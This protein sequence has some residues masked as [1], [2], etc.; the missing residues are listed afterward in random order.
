MAETEKST[1]TKAQVRYAIAEDVVN[2]DGH[3]IFDSKMYTDLGFDCMH[4]DR[5]HESN[6]SNYKEIITDSDG[7]ELMDVGGIY[8][9]DF[10]K[11][12]ADVCGLERGVDYPVQ[13]GRG[14]QAKVI[15]A[16]LEVWSAEETEDA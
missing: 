15:L 1:P 9:L 11:W 5:K 10:H 3:T 13:M 8:S 12:L 2:G 16:A 4:L 6:P 14:S 7:N